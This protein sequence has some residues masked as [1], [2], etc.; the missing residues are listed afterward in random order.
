[1]SKAS[2]LHV[3]RVDVDPAVEGS[4]NEWYDQ[5]HIPALL[6]CPGWLSA[7]RYVTLDGGPKY[8]AVY[9]IT[10]PWAYETPEYLG[11]KG[12]QE[13]EPYIRNFVRLRL[14]PIAAW[15]ASNEPGAGE[16]PT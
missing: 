4:F 1:M 13:F 11:V 2:Y 6:G 8:A 9:E 7:H 16:A 12:F 15:T 14:G 5:V 3:V 10:A